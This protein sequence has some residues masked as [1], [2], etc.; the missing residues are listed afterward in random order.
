MVEE[1]AKD[2]LTIIYLCCTVI[3]EKVLISELLGSLFGW[4]MQVIYHEFSCSIGVT[5]CGKPSPDI[6]QAVVYVENNCRDRHDS[7]SGGADK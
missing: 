1:T 6:I 7:R 4:E 3:L 2:E 5:M